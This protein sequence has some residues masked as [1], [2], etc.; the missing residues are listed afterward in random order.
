MGQIIKLLAS[1]SVSVIAT[2]VT[3][4][5]RLS[6]NYAQWFRACA[7]VLGE[8]PMIPMPILLKFFFL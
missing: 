4:V 1:V 8:N 2:M 3:I 6:W 5:I 7:F